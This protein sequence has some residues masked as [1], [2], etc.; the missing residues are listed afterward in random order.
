[1]T[2]RDAD[3]TRKPVLTYL[4][5]CGA[6]IPKGQ[7]GQHVALFCPGPIGRSTLRSRM[8]NK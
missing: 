1:M 8:V 2:D 6:Y 4:C 7:I 5:I 3:G